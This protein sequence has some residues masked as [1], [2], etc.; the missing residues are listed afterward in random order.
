MREAGAQAAGLRGTLG[1]LAGGAGPQ[2]VPEGPRFKN[3]DI[4]PPGNL[5]KV[6]VA[7]HQDVC[8]ARDCGGQD[9]AIR[10]VT[11]GNCTWFLGPRNE[12]ECRKQA[13]D[14]RNPLGR[15]P[16]LGP[17]HPPELI[18]DDLA[19]HQVVLGDSGAEYVR[20]K[21]A[22]RE[23]GYEN[24]GIEADPHETSRKTSSSVK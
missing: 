10:R 5:Q 12:W 1:V 21:A 2:E 3:P 20:A 8:R 24:V 17:Q 18:Q 6:R 14:G 22:G 19:D 9:P 11:D 7:R 16:Q 4:G 15:K 23:R 13:L